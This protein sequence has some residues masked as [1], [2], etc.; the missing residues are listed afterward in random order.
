[1]HVA[2]PKYEGS[3][4][5]DQPL[6]TAAV[7]AVLAAG[8][9]FRPRLSPW[10]GLAP[11]A[12]ASAVANFCTRVC[13]TAKSAHS[14][15]LWFAGAVIFA[16]AFYGATSFTALLDVIGLVRRGSTRRAALRLLPFLI[17]ATFALGTLA[18]VVASLTGCLR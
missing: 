5:F 16:I 13:R 10:W 7:L 14:T 9:A 1:L 18:L 6:L 15:Q 11:G 2:R 8:A 3:I 17:G 12:L 4:F